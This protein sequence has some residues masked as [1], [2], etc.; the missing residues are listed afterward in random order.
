MTIF[1]LPD[2]GEGLPDAEI[3]QWH[4]KEGDR[5]KVDD[6]LVAMETAKAVVDVP[7]PHSGKIVKLHGQKGDIIPT[8]DPLVEFE[9]VEEKGKKGATESQDTGT[10]VGEIEVGEQVVNEQALPVGNGQQGIKATP[11]IRALAKKSNVDLST[12]TPTGPNGTVTAKD[13]E[14]AAQRFV[15]A[16]PLE[17]LRGVRRNMALA[18]QQSHAQVVP[19]TIVDD[20]DISQWGSQKG[21]TVRLIQAMVYACQKES[22]LNVWYDGQAMGRRFIKGIHIGLAMDTP[23]GLFVPV[24]K[25]CQ[26]LSA[27]QLESEINT[28]KQ[29]VRDR[30]IPPEKLQGNTITLSNFGN[31]AGR[32]ANPIVVPPT[33]AILGAGK[34]REEVVAQNG[35]PTVKMRLPL[36]LSFDHRAVT[37]G[38]A[39]RFLGHLLEALQKV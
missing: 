35:D 16:G 5:V 20:A 7:S 27:T 18:M 12:L 10:V 38:E 8:G 2:L 14:H 21:F 37:G 15:E 31:F 4:V 28:L 13:I 9:L 26:D 34:V 1:H 39:T 17:P 36:S 32:Y 29:Q 24:I 11:A 22:A 25:N 30:S 6:P 19:V 23:D 33:V 3:S